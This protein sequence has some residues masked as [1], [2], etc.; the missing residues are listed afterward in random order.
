M[1]LPHPPEFNLS[2]LTSLS[3]IHSQLSLLSSYESD[4]ES[5]LAKVLSSPNLSTQSEIVRSTSSI[6]EDV[7]Q[8][9]SGIDSRI[10]TV[11]EVA[12]RIGGKIGELDEEQVGVKLGI[13]T[14][15]WV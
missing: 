4:I 12:R 2:S 5:S 15:G 14:I 3:S 9:S 13:E 11:A 1:S 8:K 6:L 10:E 7:F